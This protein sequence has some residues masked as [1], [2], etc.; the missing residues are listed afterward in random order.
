MLK[1]IS[2]LTGICLIASSALAAE[3]VE[4]TNKTSDIGEFAGEQ[5]WH[6]VPIAKRPEDISDGRDKNI[7]SKWTTNLW[8]NDR[9]SI[10]LTVKP[11]IFGIPK[12]RMAL[13]F[14]F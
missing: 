11:N 6:P 12:V 13:R 9:I 1:Y 8:E 10:P 5:I 2:I 4:K 14:T 7:N 3:S